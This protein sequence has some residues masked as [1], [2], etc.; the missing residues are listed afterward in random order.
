MKEMWREG[1]PNA[2]KC[3]VKAIPKQNLTKSATYPETPEIPEKTSQSEPHPLDPRK[4]W[5]KPHNIT[6]LLLVGCWL[7]RHAVQRLPAGA[8]IEARMS[9]Q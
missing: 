4:S 2:K 9:G 8:R 3:G 5:K 6:H 1:D 7:C